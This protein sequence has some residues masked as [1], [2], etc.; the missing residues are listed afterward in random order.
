M[1]QQPNSGDE[2]TPQPT[3]N[4]PTPPTSR[5]VWLRR[6]RRYGLPIGGVALAGLAAGGWWGWVFVN[7][8]LSP[9]IEKNLSES[10]KRPVK[11]GRVERF[12]L[13]SLRVGASEVPATATDPDQLS[14]GALE[15]SFDPV[16]ILLTRN[17]NLGITVERPSIYLE[18]D[19]DGNWISTQI[20]QKEEEGPVKT[21]IESVRI[22]DAQVVLVPWAKSG[23]KQAAAIRINQ[24]NGT[25]NFFDNSERIAYE[26]SAQ[27]ATGGS[28]DL[29][30]ET[31]QKPKQP[32]QTK[33]EIRVQ[34]FLVSEIDRLVKLPV[35]LE[36]GRADG[37]IQVALLPDEAQPKVDGTAQ[38]K[39][40]TLAI[41]QVPTKFS[42]A[43][44]ALQLRGTLIRLEN[45]NTL[46]GQVPVQAN[47]DIDT[48]K[49]F[50][51]KAKVK[52]V[53]LAKVIEA[54]ALTL[55]IA[56]EGEIEA[57]LEV[58]GV[59]DKPVLNGLAR[60]TQPGRIDQIDFSRFSTAFKVDT[61]AQLLTIAELQASL[62]A[63]GQVTGSGRV[64]LTDRPMVDFTARLA[65]IFTDPIVQAYA[66]SNAPKFST[67]LLN[68][69]AQITG[70]ADAVV[71]DIAQ[72]QVNPGIGGSITG[73]GRITV[74]EQT[75][76]ALNTQVNNVPADPIV[77]SYGQA[78]PFSVGL[79]NG[80][81]QIAGPADGLV[82]TIPSFQINPPSG[83][84]I[85]GNGK[86]DTGQS[87][88]A[89]TVRAE[90]LQ[91]GAI[92][93]A[94]AGEKLPFSVGAVNA[95]A[96]L[97]GSFASPTIVVRD[98]VA[99]VAGGTVG[100]QARLANGS[101][102]ATTQIAQV[103]LG[104]FSPDLRGVSNGEFTASGTGFTPAEFVA[105]GN[106]TLSE[107]LA[108]V[109]Q[110]IAAKLAWDG[111]KLLIPSA[112]S[113]GL[114]VDGAVYAN[115]Q[116]TPSID[117]FD[118][119]VRGTDYDL[120]AIAL[121]L[122]SNIRFSGRSD[123]SGKVTGTPAASVVATDVTL[124]QFIL[125]GLA[126]ES[127]LVGKLR[128]DRGVDLNLRG[129]Q[130][131]IALTLNSEYLP[132][133]FDVRQ[134]TTIATGRTQGGLLTINAEQVP[135]SLVS[136]GTEPIGGT[137]TGT[138][139]LNPRQLSNPSQLALNGQL[140]IAKPSFGTYRADQFGG[141]VTLNNGVA[142]LNNAEI[143]RGDTVFRITASSALFAASPQAQGK[144]EVT[145][146]RL[147]DV[148][149]LA[150]VFDLADL[151]R[152]ARPPSYGDAFDLDT[153]PIALANTP[154]LDQLRRLSEIKARRA[155]V[156]A[157]RKDSPLPGLDELDG[158]F[159]STVTFNGSLQKGFNATLSLR[160]Q[161]WKWGSFSAQQVVVDANFENGV[162]SLLP[163][164]FQSGDAFVAFTGQLSAQ[165]QS[166]QLRVVNVPIADLTALSPTPVPL[167][168]EGK[169]NAT[170]TLAGTLLNPQAVGVLSL[171]QGSLNGTDIRSAR[172]SFRFENARL[173]F[174]SALLVQ[175]TQ[176]L[177]I[178]G[179]IPQLL[180]IP[181]VTPDNNE[182]RL[183]INVADDGL[184]FLNLLNTQVAWVDGKGQVKVQ[185]RGTRDRPIVS[186]SAE[187]QNATLRA[188]ALPELLTGVNGSIAFESDR[189]RVRGIQGQY[190]KQQGQVEAA[191]VLPLFQRLAARDADAASPLQVG[192]K[193][194]N[195]TLK[196]LYTGGVNGLVE[197]T[198]TALNPAI[199]GQITLS[200]GQV[201]LTDPPAEPP[202]ATD[203]AT[204]PSSPAAAPTDS[205]SNVEFANLRIRL[206]NSIRIVRQPII[207]FVAAGDLTIKGTLS[208]PN[209]EGTIRLTA[210][211]VNLFTTQFN[212]VRGYSQTATFL[213]NQGIDPVLNVRL[214][215]SVA[216]STGYR[217][218]TALLPSEVLDTPPPSATIGGVQ[219][220]RIQADVEGRASELFQN[221][222]LTS[223]PGR[224][225]TEL[226]ALIGGS[227][228][229]TFGQGSGALGLAN[230]AGSALLTN[231]QTTV[232]NV[233]GLSEFRLFPTLI[234]DNS[235]NERDR[236][237]RRS[238][239]SIGL[240]IEGAIDLSPSLSLS[241]VGI[242][243]SGQP[244]QFGLR[245]RLS[246]QFILRG[247]SDFSGDNRTVLEY[248]T[249]F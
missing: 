181:P 212:L 16:R 248:E 207:N 52:P 22:R 125:N 1:T 82:V 142:T 93:Q 162:L 236:T 218:P 94:Y 111:Q 98:A 232:G 228:V 87:Q 127:P 166:G 247:S 226:L 21:E 56:T 213:P 24:A 205:G 33:A 174:D 29:E 100:L 11:L 101:W 37:A 179:S 105:Q 161:D 225:E 186:G 209:P 168:L 206:G 151:T 86:V 242:I 210:G 36:G 48:D 208:D 12:S 109:R 72:L 118:L 141:Q 8:Q 26:L 15:V 5:R 64:A 150:Q 46:Y 164:R 122:P 71:I 28:V 19:K 195:L 40:V 224:S 85:T 92:A 44:G 30:G 31:L 107:G 190:G 170:A 69:Q 145:Q 76:V 192:L 10:L 7:E 215:A 80:E 83:G 238:A 54:L 191:G 43:S 95:T 139:T 237:S 27:T 154:V 152:G 163:V 113:P 172:G 13:T 41:P 165:Q 114:S 200:D 133:A 148:L 128:V 177:T 34:N 143:R 222:K 132:V 18:Q 39:G 185:V 14:I 234:R 173:N 90:N 160:G 131:Q 249:R 2:P 9:L 202:P 53:S 134:G 124:R 217:Q 75:I 180:P 47:G 63:G 61:A 38:F 246:D 60:S 239:S 147:K 45:V 243:G 59:I 102:Q 81:A 159:N 97:A 23:K 176:P 204:P 88:V 67:G 220:I 144:V 189:L 66:G 120:T 78:L 169:L 198:G 108:V 129:R 140:T 58:V 199:G 167:D 84:V 183:D 138:V 219:T 240:G 70:P 135:L 214:L 241:A 229:N 171:D 79:V 99:A 233:L 158:R 194:L 117:R 32:P 68:A 227:F 201:Q 211:Q 193:K 182:L 89:V 50:Q 184:S 126:F 112:T 119:N 146:G 216:E 103:Q 188:T 62:A 245:Y 51:L 35:D 178:A 187:V 65:N 123:F 57:D 175:G 91:G 3:G 20:E 116:G 231:V 203:N 74:G 42:Q 153:T 49:G 25:V 221:L 155:R 106:I 137:V 73:S 197:I 149:E 157:Q 6:L 55:P 77:Q 115:L 121:P 17:L 235:I 196:G 4:E 130:D 136:L 156:E 110:P 230:L 223:R 104:Q 244:P 96:E